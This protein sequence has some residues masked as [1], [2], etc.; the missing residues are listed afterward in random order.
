[1]K[2]RW[3]KVLE[4]KKNAQPMKQAE[5]KLCEI[6]G[7]LNHCPVWKQFQKYNRDTV[8]GKKNSSGLHW[9]QIANSNK[10]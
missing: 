9:M 6:R 7:S 1:M 4:K 5:R 8:L 2:I 10:L 3:I